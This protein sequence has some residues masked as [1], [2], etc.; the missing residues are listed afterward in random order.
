LKQRHPGKKPGG[1]VF[2][3]PRGDFCI[4]R[5]TQI[6]ADYFGKMG[7]GQGLSLFESNGTH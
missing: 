3:L 2:S 4:R 7:A 1:A 6:G 5:L